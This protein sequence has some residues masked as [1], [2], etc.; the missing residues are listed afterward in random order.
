MPLA[1]GRGWTAGSSTMS[2]VWG[3]GAVVPSISVPQQVDIALFE[4]SAVAVGRYASVAKCMLLCRCEML[5]IPH[6][7][8]GSTTH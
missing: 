2:A 4:E 8:L 3:G 1:R 7:I 6:S 5:A